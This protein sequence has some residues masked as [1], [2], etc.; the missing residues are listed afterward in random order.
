[1]RVINVEKLVLNVFVGESGDK[2]VALQRRG[3]FPRHDHCCIDSDSW[4]DCRKIITQ[5]SCDGVD[6][7]LWSVFDECAE[8]CKEN[9]ASD[10]TTVECCP[11]VDLQKAPRRVSPS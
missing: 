9:G 7:E 2:L 5:S 3:A 11:K 10:P 8:F 1:M 4:K 6:Y